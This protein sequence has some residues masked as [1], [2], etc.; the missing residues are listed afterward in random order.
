MDGQNFDEL[1][2]KL[3][4]GISR[5]SVLR[6]PIGGGAAL[7]GAKAASTAAAGKTTICHFPPGNP[8]NVQKITIASP[9]VASHLAHG[10]YLYENCCVDG[11]CAPGSSCAS[12]SCTAMC[13]PKTCSE[14]GKQCGNWDDGCGGSINCD[15]CAAGDSCH[16]A[17]CDASGTCSEILIARTCFIDG[18]CYDAGDSRPGNECET[19]NPAVDPTTWIPVLSDESK[20]CDDF[21]PCFVNGMCD[22]W[23]NCAGMSPALCPAA[24]E[25]HQYT[26]EGDQCCVS[27]SKPDGTPC[28]NGAGTCRDG[29]CSA[30]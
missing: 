5:R 29:S 11:D 13:L 8:G 25:C 28:Q 10:D 21:P 2:R 6:G 14:L 4:T 30:G 22:G 3:A 24:D 19:C 7:I 17:V 26:H 23:G 18:Q 27:S 16:Q 9:A 20:V 1:T 12:G 15:D